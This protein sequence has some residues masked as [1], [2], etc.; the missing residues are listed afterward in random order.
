MA[1]LL[2]AIALL[3][4]APRGGHAKPLEPRGGH[5]LTVREP[6][7]NAHA[8]DCIH[9]HEGAW[10]DVGDP[11]WGGLQFDRNFMA[12]YGSDML[13][14]YGGLA[15]LWSPRDQMVVAER[16]RRVRGYY[17]WPQT[18]RYCGLI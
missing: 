17:P 12:T 6:I 7:G 2:T 14:R 1:V 11:Y 10:N 16:A 4:P 8:W 9:R 15:N 5:A 13:R 3:V 18:A